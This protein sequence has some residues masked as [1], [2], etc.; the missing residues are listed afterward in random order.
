MPLKVNQFGYSTSTKKLTCG[1]KQVHD[2]TPYEFDKKWVK[3]RGALRVGTFNTWGSAHFSKISLLS[4]RIPYMIQMLIDEDLDVIALQ[5]VCQEILDALLKH[6]YFRDYYFSTVKQPWKSGK[7]QVDKSPYRGH[8]PNCWSVTL[9]RLPI[10]QCN[11]L[12][13][14]SESFDFTAVVVDVGIACVVNLHLQS[15]GMA[16]GKNKKDGLKYHTCRKQQFKAIK[17]YVDQHYQ[18]NKVIY[19]GDYNFDLDGKKK[20]VVF[21]EQSVIK[22]L[23][24]AGKECNNI[25]ATEDTHVNTMRYCIKKQHK[26][27]RY[28]GIL[29]NHSS[30]IPQSV[31]LFGK[32]PIFSIT[33]SKFKSIMK[34]DPI[35]SHDGKVDWFVSD[36]FGVTC[37]F[38]H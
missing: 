1:I 8:E 3:T 25:E 7:I 23:A 31:E 4:K 12:K 32:L 2:I 13:L 18:S 22:G 17:K 36:H 19:L 10:Y 6:K 30:L 11:Y 16:S 37:E 20:G 24:D 21:P 9:S 35:V 27:Y 29:Y 33:K 15:G 14:A 28:D 5:E 38:H 26:Q 34:C